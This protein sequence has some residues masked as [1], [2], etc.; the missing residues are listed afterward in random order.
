MEEGKG[1]MDQNV[2]PLKEILNNYADL[3]WSD[4][5]FVDKDQKITLE[6]MCLIHDP[7]DISNDDIDLPDAAIN[8]GYDYLI[9]AQSLQ[10]ICINLS[11]QMEN[12]SMADKLHALIYYL[13]NDAF[14]VI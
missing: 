14:M 6:T 11:A 7:D 1:N 8:L 10:S 13:E 2:I 3:T 5:V 9:D 4:A 12:P